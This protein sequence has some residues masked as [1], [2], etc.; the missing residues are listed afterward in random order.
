M[1]AVFAYARLQIA[2]LEKHVLCDL[3]FAEYSNYSLCWS[4]PD[5]HRQISLTSAFG[6][7]GFTRTTFNHAKVLMV[8]PIAAFK[9]A[10]E[11]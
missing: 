1:Q 8:V 3:H 7:A 9:S 4:F 10:K 5:A 2:R 11:I 6:G